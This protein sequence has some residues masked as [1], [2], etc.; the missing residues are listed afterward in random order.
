MTERRSIGVTGVVQGVG[1][2][3]FVYELAT[4]LGLAG[5]V[6]NR[7]GRVEIE[8][9]GERAALE[10]FLSELRGR[11]PALARVDEVACSA[12][13][14][15]GE[16]GFSITASAAG[17]PADVFL[18]PDVATC[19]AC[20]RELFDPLDR[21]Y[22]YP[23][24]NCTQCGPRL[25]ITRAVPYDRA[26]T[27]LA[28]FPLCE[29]CR[30]EYEDPRDRRFHA[31][32][33]ACPAC[34]PRVSLTTGRGEPLH[35]APRSDEGAYEGPTA[36]A[37]TPASAF[38]PIAALARELLAGKIAGIK[39]LGGYHLACDARSEAAVQ[40]LRRRKHRLEKPFAVMVADAAAAERLCELSSDEVSALTSPARP[41]VLLRARS[42]SG[43][44]ASVAP[45][46][47]WLGVMLPYTPLH[48]LLLA[49]LQGAPLVMT[50][51]NPSDDPIAYED[52][53]ARARLGEIADLLLTHDRP[54]HLRCDD[55]V[56]RVVPSG[57]LPLRRAR[58]LAP[59]P[60]KLP[61]PLAR[62]TLALGAQ[63]KSTFCIGA[64][65][66]AVV[67]HHL[68][69]LDHFQAYQAFTEAISHYERLY[70]ISPQR[71][72]HDLH[73]DYAST[74]YAQERAAA[75]GVELVGVQHHHAHFAA[76]LAEHG[77]SGQAIGVTFDGTG[78]GTDGTVWG[79]EWLVGGCAAARRAL[80]LRPVPLPGGEQAIREPWR[81]AVAY[82]L[83]AEVEPAGLPG[84]EV[85]ALRGVRQLVETR[86]LCPLTSSAGRLFDAVAFL[87]GGPGRVSFE[88]QAASWLE[89]LAGGARAEPYEFAI[90]GEQVD[91]RPLVRAVW[92]EARRGV[93]AVQSARRF[94]STLAEVI[95]AGC[96]QLSAQTGVRTVALSG[97]VF[98]N[99][100]LLTQAREALQ[101]EGL[102]VLT[103]RLVPANDG[104][105]SYGQ[106][107]VVA[108][109]DASG[110]VGTG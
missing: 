83:S 25:T 101:A 29:A 35:P 75:S 37:S 28:G 80:R 103:H 108:A 84:V 14:P 93:P 90:S 99:A 47:P 7:Q 57:V 89:G 78:F 106:L 54:I 61:A 97:G 109:R 12:V 63:L 51:G 95:R 34:G 73:P 91:W 94:H 40:T 46:S 67:S 96:V 72:V 41:I 50:S 43:V 69:D 53:D 9:E 30:A 104:G 70:R 48:H 86:A 65:R 68:G 31:Q 77:V 23:F 13:E 66:D 26:T 56:V 49:E 22:R 11:P 74:Q 39:G 42:P 105:I 102:T 60:L 82:L 62:P 81:M 64:G 18:S 52:A 58:G 16:R 4:R 33:T 38:E 107:A 6:R 24:L 32:P 100:L 79:G 36:P 88:A 10:T 2:R 76:C 8:V 45:G 44:A 20:L 59:S 55:S 17:G 71:L 85:P 5:F 1:F 110:P 87:L 3:P 98:C 19:E 21:R 92:D 15:L 27:T